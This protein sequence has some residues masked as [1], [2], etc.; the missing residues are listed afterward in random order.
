MTACASEI[1]VLGGG[2]D[3]ST[4]GPSGRPEVDKSREDGRAGP[5]DGRR[6]WELAA[7]GSYAARLAGTAERGLYV[8][9]WALGDSDAYTVE[10]PVDRPETPGSALLALADGRVLVARPGD[11]SHEFSLLYP[12]GPGTGQLPLGAVESDRLTLLPPCPDGN[13][14]HA[15][16][17]GFETT[18]IWLVA[19]ADAPRPVADVPGHCLDGQWLDPSGRLLALNRRDTAGRT[20]TV[21]ADL[22]RGGEV[23]PLL[24]LGERSND[25]L[26]LADPHSGLLLVCSDAPGRMRMGWGVLGSHLPVRFPQALHQ[27]ELRLVPFTV[28]H[29]QQLMPERSSVALRAQGPNGT[30]VALWRPGQRG[31]R[32]LTAPPGWLPGAGAFGADGELRLPYAQGGVRGVARI[33]RTPAAR[34]AEGQR[35][36]GAGYG[37]GAGGRGL[38]ARG[39][40]GAHGQ[41]PG[42]ADG[43]RTGGALRT[44]GSGGASGAGGAGGALRTSGASGAGGAGGAGAP[45]G[46]RADGTCGGADAGGEPGAMGRPFV[47][48]PVSGPVS[49]PT[50]PSARTAHGGPTAAPDRSA[51]VPATQADGAGHG[52]AEPFPAPSPTEGSGTTVRGSGSARLFTPVPLQQAPLAAAAA[53]STGTGG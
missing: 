42:A 40:D 26:L 16:V 9:R 32:H 12:T 43:P 15:L 41:G 30:W 29:G 17:P 20:T 46:P 35:Q 39:H 36:P 22:A 4:R 48:Q 3:S 28:Q 2:N 53:G 25:R 47:P 37:P 10:L 31:L 23:S 51:T 52:S 18:A 8:E 1:T 13:T 44:S 19:G 7:D 6:G 38:A 14:A 21:V 45:G 33:G 49:V 27:E 34:P 11:G 24:E 5:Q 50:A